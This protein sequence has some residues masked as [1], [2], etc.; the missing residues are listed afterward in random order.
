MHLLLISDVMFVYTYTQPPVH[1]WKLWLCAQNLH[2]F[3]C[4]L[5]VRHRAD[6]CSPSKMVRHFCLLGAESKPNLYKTHVSYHLDSIINSNTRLG[7][8]LLNLQRINL[9]EYP[10]VRFPWKQ[11]TNYS[12]CKPECITIVRVMV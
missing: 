9:V 5:Y 2:N 4:F 1:L 10:S 12:N 3:Q 8:T 7:F 11:N 6:T